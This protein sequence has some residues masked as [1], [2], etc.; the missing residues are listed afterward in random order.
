MAAS[1]NRHQDL[2]AAIPDWPDLQ[3]GGEDI[4]TMLSRMTKLFVEAMYTCIKWTLNNQWSFGHRLDSHRDVHSES[5]HSTMSR[6]GWFRTWNTSQLTTA[7]SGLEC[8]NSTMSG[9]A[10]THDSLLKNI[11][12]TM[13]GGGCLFI[14]HRLESPKHRAS[15]GLHMNYYVHRQHH[16]QSQ[17]T[18]GCHMR[19]KQCT[20]KQFENMALTRQSK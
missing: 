7:F 1:P 17:W 20:L 13:S 10:C 8:N 3:F 11:H 12:S 18:I 2:T 15:R 5:M 6:G 4:K 19:R 16:T 14:D 9:G